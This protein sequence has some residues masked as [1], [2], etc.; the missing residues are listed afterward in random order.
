MAWS[1]PVKTTVDHSAKF[2]THQLEMDTII[3]QGGYLLKDGLGD[4]DGQVNQRKQ[5]FSHSTTVLL[6]NMNFNNPNP[7][8]NPNPNHNYNAFS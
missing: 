2:Y 1:V 6:N 3:I 5:D 7:N 8:P 4:Q